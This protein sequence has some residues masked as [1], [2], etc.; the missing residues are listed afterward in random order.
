MGS[1]VKGKVGNMEDNTKEE[2][3]RRKREYVVV[4]VKDIVV[5]NNFLVQFEDG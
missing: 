4:Y 1:C 2:R 3:S 5:K